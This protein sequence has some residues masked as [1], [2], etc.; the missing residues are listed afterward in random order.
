MSVPHAPHSAAYLGQ[1]DKCGHAR[2][3]VRLNRGRNR[4]S[5]GA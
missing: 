5:Y 2:T 3:Y 1:G 4:R